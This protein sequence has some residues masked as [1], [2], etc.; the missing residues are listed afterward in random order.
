M[1]R[2]LESIESNLT[3][4]A[5]TVGPWLAPLPSA[6]FVWRA[7][8]NHLSLPGWV[9]LVAAGVIELLGLAATAQALTIYEYNTNRRKTD[10]AA[11]L[12][13]AVALLGVYFLGVIALTVALEVLPE[14]VTFAPALFPVL[15]LAGVGVL[16]LRLDHRRRLESIVQEKAER[17]AERQAARQAIINQP[18]SEPVKLPSTGGKVDANLDRL[19]AGRQAAL[20]RR[21]DS[22]LDIYL[23]NPGLQPSDAARRL[24]TSRQTIYAYLERLESAGRIRRNG[25]GVEVLR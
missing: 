17:K 22:L 2:I 7:G 3:A 4:L 25:H 23:D 11:P 10:Q 15:S 20:D 6:F 16:A 9:A 21:L 19:N 12:V 24:G 13:L 5:A 14:L 8:V 18:S 1:Q